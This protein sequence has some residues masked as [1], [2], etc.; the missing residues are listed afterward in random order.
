MENSAIPKRERSAGFR[1]GIITRDPTSRE[2]SS[3]AETEPLVFSI[4]ASYF[5]RR[6]L[7]TVLY[8]R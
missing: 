4:G 6:V 2:Y 7:A 3:L 5:I 8:K 1:D